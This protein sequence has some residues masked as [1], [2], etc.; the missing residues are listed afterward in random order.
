MVKL[1]YNAYQGSTSDNTVLSAW[2]VT[3]PWYVLVGRALSDKVT[4]GQ[5]EVQYVPREYLR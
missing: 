4:D 1:R 5:V 2:L 3:V